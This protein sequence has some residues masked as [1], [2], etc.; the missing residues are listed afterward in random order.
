MGGT[1]KQKNDQC[2]K[3]PKREWRKEDCT[4]KVDEEEEYF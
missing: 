3:Y 1:R 2:D 4:F